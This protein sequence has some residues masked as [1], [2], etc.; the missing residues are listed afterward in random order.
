M[1]NHNKDPSELAPLRSMLGQTELEPDARRLG[2]ALK[3]LA[4]EPLEEASPADWAALEEQTLALAHR[5]RRRYHLGEFW[6]SLGPA[7]LGLCVAGLALFLIIGTLGVRSLSSVLG[8]ARPPMAK[9]MPPASIAA[10]AETIERLEL[11]SGSGNGSAEATL[12]CGAN[13]QVADGSAEVD[14]KEAYRP[15]IHLRHGRVAVS[16]PPL[17]NGGSLTVWTSDA[18]VIVHGT[19]FV[20][21]RREQEDLTLVSVQEGLV[22]VQPVGGKRQAVFLG[23]GEQ[24]SVPSSASYFRQLAT[25]VGELIDSGHCDEKTS[26]VL[27][28]YLDNAAADLDVSAAVYLKGNCAAAKGDLATALSAFE[29]VATTTKSALRAENALARSAQLRGKRDAADGAAAWRLYLS[30]FPQGQ[31]RESAQRYLRE[32]PKARAPSE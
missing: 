32:L 26:V 2:L 21:D 1:A 20:V 14:Q 3:D 30:R 27:D 8:N 6:R 12:R 15:R 23:S 10:P 13:L 17:P 9:R 5:R 18:E 11:P 7:Q 29:R 16:V 4:D 28:A 25:E 22:E 31:H 19:H 24:V